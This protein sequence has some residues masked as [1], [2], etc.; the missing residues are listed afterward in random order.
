[1]VAIGIDLGTTYS[2]VGWWKD[3]RCDII[4]NDQGNRTTPSYVAFTDTERLIGDG[5]KNQSSMNPNNTVFDAK[6]L[7]GR[8]FDDKALQSDIK[9][10][11][12][13]VK[14]K[15]N[16]PIIEVEY[17]GEKKDYLPEEISSMVLIKM[18][19]IAEAY[20]GEEVT[21]AVITVPAYFNDSQRQ[22][23][24]DAG[25]IAGLNVLRI[26]NEPTAAA[27]AYGLDNKEGGEKNILIFDLGGGTFDVSLLNIED[28]IFE[29]KA[30][31]GD[32]HLGGEDFDNILV[33]HFS[34][35]FKR[36][37]NN[38]LSDNKRSLRRLRTACEKAKRTLSS[39]NSASIEID[40]L[41]DGIDFFTSIS[42]A[43][44]ESLC[45]P[46]FNKCIEPVSR[47]L[48]DSK[49]SKSSI[50]DIVLVGG[51]TRI[52]K[53]QE[54]LSAFF[55][56]KELSKS[57]NPD[58][59]VAY[60]ASVQAAILS[61]TNQKDDD[62]DQILLL[63]VAPLSLGLETAGG[64]MTKIIERNTTIPTKKTQ[65]FSTYQDNQ[66]AVTIQVFEG[67]RQMTKDNNQLGTFELNGIPP[68]PRGVPQIEVTFDL[69]ANGIMN[70]EASDKGSGKKETLTITNDKDR[71][72]AEDIERMV[73]EA[74]Q[75]RDE[76][77]ALKMKIEAK[78]NLESL[79]FRMKTDVTNDKLTPEDK[80]TMNDSIK[81]LEEWLL[82]EDRTKEEY[83]EKLTSIGSSIES[84]MAKLNPQPGPGSMGSESMGIN[85]NDVMDSGN[86]E[87]TIDEVD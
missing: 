40:S 53:V 17:K 64:I 57:I 10:F 81:D 38:D 60:G 12:F 75:F 11:P 26:I 67:E 83:E 37:H 73:K 87:P 25:A 21:D 80:D 31:A 56:G 14:D 50:N 72:S 29:V 47:V 28:G 52:P 22:S 85:P 5:A 7:I 68:A 27:I 70:I 58:E 44:F 20:I 63:D 74:D 41:Y 34:D 23:T 49:V 48:Q 61:G 84:I 18:K 1:M 16:K 54:L 77:N 13:T 19:E 4:A 65:T 32:T 51:S 42:R 3:N 2:C 69:D 79:L 6:R 82:N 71:L 43:K 76:D 66:P 15:S 45:M 33:K 36:K 86:P 62:A 9:Q 46:L 35:E 59:A 8:S 78:N 30:T 24:K 39:G 55:N